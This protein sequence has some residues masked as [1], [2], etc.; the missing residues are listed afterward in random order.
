MFAKRRTAVDGVSMCYFFAREEPV[1]NLIWLDDFLALAATGNFS[2]AAD[3]RHS[4]QPAF[5]RR[6]RALEAWVGSDLV[7]RTSQPAKLTP[8]GEWIRDVAEDLLA[9]VAR[10]PGELKRVAEASSVTLRIASTHALSFTFLP[11]WLHGLEMHTTLGPVHLVSDVLQGCEA[12]MM[13]SK[14]QFVLGHAHPKAPGA[15][16]VDD[17]RSAQIGDDVLIPVSQPDERGKPRYQLSLKD[18]PTVPVMRYTDE[19]GLGR[20]IRAVLGNR[21]QA[22]PIDV[23]FTA[24]LASVLR[25]MV[26]DGKGLAWIPKSLIRDDLTQ[27]RLVPAAETIWNVPVEIR[28][29]RERNPIGKA[30]EAF[31]GSAVGP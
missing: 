2:R 7:D 10:V 19:S 25:T 15:L 30:A 6:I 3:D 29:Y 4:S 12:L 27:Q 8:A 11:L 16:D 5:S 14:V 21:L 23:V 22:Y 17:Y 18:G 13:Q 9:R 24:H 28:L 26:L 31:W 1:M 20:I